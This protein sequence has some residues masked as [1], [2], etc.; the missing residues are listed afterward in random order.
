MTNELD[1]YYENLKSKG[2]DDATIKEMK[3]ALPKET[4]EKEAP[5]ESLVKKIKKVLKK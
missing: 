1:W 3:A 4:S 2:F 5:K